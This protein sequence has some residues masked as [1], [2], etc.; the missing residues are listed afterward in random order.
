MNILIDTNIV[1]SLEPTSPT[2]VEPRTRVASELVRFAGAGGHHL[3]LH[4]ES[5]REL[6]ADRDPDRR[7]VRDVLTRKYERLDPAPALASEVRMTAGDAPAGSHDYVDHMMLSAVLADAV[8]FLVTDDGGILRKASKLG[9][10]DRVLT[11]EDAL[12]LLRRLEGRTPAPPPLVVFTK[13]YA[14]TDSDPIFVSFREDYPHFDAWLRKCKLEQRPAWVIR[15]AEDGP[16]SALCIVKERDDELALGG[17]TLKVCSLKVSEERQGRRYGEL[18]LKTLFLY[19]REKRYEYAFVTV[20]ERHAGLIALL[21][22]FGFRRHVQDT[23]LG[24]RILVKELRGSPDQLEA[25][26]PLEFH[27]T[28]GPPAIKLVDGDVFLVPIQP[29]YHKL[30]FPDA[31]HQSE[32]DSQLE[33]DLGLPPRRAPEPYGNALRKAYL[34]H[35]PNRQLGPGSTLLFYRSQDAKAV[36]CVGIVEDTLVSTKAD[37]VVAFVGQRTVYSAD[38]IE[39]M[40]R[41]GPVLAVLFRQ[42]RLLPTPIRR[43]ELVSERVV[44]QAPQSIC[45]VPAEVIPWL[46]VRLGE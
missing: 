3:F 22:D 23:L 13:A 45:R 1:I 28:F 19:L 16:L 40:C 8:Q 43:Q 36:T 7:A 46:D 37:E 27:R 15:D 4:P 26:Q 31:E 41:R 6:S 30:L 32:P 20:F 17:P 10:G 2:D 34:C 24:E 29:R 14:L 11:A 21:E 12:T 42:D 9:L 35:S 39:G 33:L 44:T 38:D 18:L 25:M 5:L